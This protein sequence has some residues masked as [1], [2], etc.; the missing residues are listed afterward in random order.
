MGLQDQYESVQCYNCILSLLCFRGSGLL[1]ALLHWTSMSLVR[2]EG[3]TETTEY[4]VT[5][6]YSLTA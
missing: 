5:A 6:V 1:A 2:S 4:S 3:L